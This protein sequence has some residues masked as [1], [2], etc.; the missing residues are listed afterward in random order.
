MHISMSAL[1]SSGQFYRAEMRTADTR[2]SFAGIVFLSILLA[3]TFK[4]NCNQFMLS[5]IISHL[6]VP[7]QFV[8]DQFLLS[9]LAS[10]TSKQVFRPSC[11]HFCNA[12]S[13]GFVFPLMS[14]TSKTKPIFPKCASKVS[15][16]LPSLFTQLTLPIHTLAHVYTQTHT[17]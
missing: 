16:T 14:N 3:R 15:I 12:S 9:N 7:L 2:F 8:T 11:P 13:V 1:S 5:C 6:L 10:T 17:S 4:T